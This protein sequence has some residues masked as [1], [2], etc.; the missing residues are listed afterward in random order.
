VQR[1]ALIP[2]RQSLVL[3]FMAA[4]VG[5]VGVALMLSLLMLLAGLRRGPILDPNDIMEVSMVV[6]P[7]TESRMPERATR[8]PVPRGED[9][10]TAPQPKPPVESDLAVVQPDAPKAEGSP[11]HSDRRTELM[12]ELRRKQLLADAAADIGAV[13]REA[14]DPDSTT[15]QAVNTGGSGAAADPE[16]ALWVQKVREKFMA[17]FHPLPTIVSANP[18]IEATVAVRIDEAGNV[19]SRSMH[20]P[21]GNPS[22][23]AAAERAADAVTQVPP[24]PE[25][26]RDTE[27]TL[28]IRFSQ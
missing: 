21:S 25:K 10:P 28:A 23:D 9:T 7:K 14:S 17:N 6:L 12:K 22:Y 26:Y 1:S 15:D 8:A 19:L 11:D 2:E 24:P 3:P 18:N 13:D 27:H 4:L 20:K 5:H 16:L